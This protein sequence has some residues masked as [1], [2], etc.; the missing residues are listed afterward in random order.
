MRECDRNQS[1]THAFMLP[2]LYLIFLRCCYGDLKIGSQGFSKPLAVGKKAGRT[3]YCGQ[4]K[5]QYFY[6]DALATALYR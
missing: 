2:E 5:S 3:F 4:G 6:S 1:M